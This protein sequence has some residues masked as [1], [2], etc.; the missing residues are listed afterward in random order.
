MKILFKKG[1]VPVSIDIILEKD[2]SFKSIQK[3]SGSELK[4]EDYE[5]SE[6]EEKNVIKLVTSSGENYTV[7]TVI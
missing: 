3:T 1:P 4:P 7:R 2:G 5:V 6:T